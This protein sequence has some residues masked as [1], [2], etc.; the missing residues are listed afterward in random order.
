MGRNRA[1]VLSPDYDI[2]E[3][4]KAYVLTFDMPGMDK[5][6]ISVE[7]KEGVLMV[8]GERSSES[9]EDQGNKVYRQQ[10]SFGYFSR[11]IMLPENVDP[12]AVQAKYDNGVLTVT[13]G[14]KEEAQK[15]AASRK[16]EIK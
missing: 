15:K 16:V 1:G 11:S 3:N 10:R 12:N 8:S 5:S 6:K 9:Q 13:V 7:V 2:K 4:D 14:K